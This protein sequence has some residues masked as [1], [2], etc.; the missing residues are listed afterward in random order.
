MKS[1]GRLY[2]LAMAV[3]LATGCWSENKQPSDD[4]YIG[5]PYCPP[6]NCANQLHIYVERRDQTVFSS[7]MYAFEIE[8]EPGNLLKLTC[9]LDDQLSLSC[10]GDTGMVRIG[11][12]VSGKQISLG[13]DATPT[14][15]L[16]MAYF[17]DEEIGSDLLVPKYQ[18][19]TALDPACTESCEEGACTLKVASPKTSQ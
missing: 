19:I 6:L 1:G 8:I 14:Q 12:N 9:Q 5:G 15:V 7:G 17:E 3:L 13:V 11:I 4:G 18:I 16:V 10:D 2:H